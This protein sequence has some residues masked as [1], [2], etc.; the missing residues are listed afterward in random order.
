LK[1][2]DISENNE[3]YVV[4]D[5]VLFCKDRTVLVAYP[6]QHSS[7]YSIPDTVTEIG[8]HAFEGC[9]GLTSV[10]IPDS[11]TAIG[12]QAFYKCFGMTSVTIPDSVTEIGWYAFEDCPNLTV[13][14]SKESCAWAHCEK[15]NVP[16]KELTETPE[17][18]LAEPCAAEPASAEEPVSAPAVESVTKP[19]EEPA[20]ARRSSA[21]W[22]IPA[23]LALALGG[24]AAVQLSGLFDILGAI[25]SLLG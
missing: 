17:P 7:S 20:P 9:S 1:R 16:H 3:R 6:N 2:I 8:N 25:G 5:G 21:W 19:A 12:N 15:N 4:I 22:L 10:T 23:A 24:A 14:C 18:V 11:V 13:Y